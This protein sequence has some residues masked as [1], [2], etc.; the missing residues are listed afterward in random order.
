MDLALGA[1]FATSASLLVFDPAPSAFGASL[2][3]A[4]WWLLMQLRLPL[5]HRMIRH[6]RPSKERVNA[7]LV[8]RR[9]VDLASLHRKES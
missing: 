4:P 3:A 9:A 5:M 1:K 6:P 8:S 2:A 7:S